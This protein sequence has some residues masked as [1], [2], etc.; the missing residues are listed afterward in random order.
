MERTLIVWT[1]LTGIREI[2]MLEKTWPPTWKTPMG[3][4]S[5]K[6]VFVGERS[7][8]NRITGDMSSKQ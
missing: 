6:M 1:V 5:L 2:A 3:I 7:L 4:V 8:E